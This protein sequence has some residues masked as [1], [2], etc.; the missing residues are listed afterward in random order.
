M[1]RFLLLALAVAPALCQAP[2]FEVASIKPSTPESA[3]LTSTFGPATLLLPRTTLKFLIVQ[4]YGMQPDLISGLSPWMWQDPYDVIGK[5]SS[6]FTRQQ[7]NE[8]LQTLLA[9]RFQLKLHHE[10][11]SIPAYVLI[12]AKG[13]SKLTPLGQSSPGINRDGGT[14]TLRGP[15]GTLV[16]V[17]GGYLGDRTFPA[18]GAP[19]LTPPEQLPV[20][21]HTNLTGMYEFKLDMSRSTDWFEILEPQLGLKLEKRKLSVDTIV[22]DSA[23]KPSAN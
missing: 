23:A 14:L 4:A 11:K 20:F 9:D 10:Q 16:T 18:P 8:M 3:N 21:D 1:R 19:P 6:Q 17:I 2:S 15:V 7:G 22:I 12:V 13:G 5:S